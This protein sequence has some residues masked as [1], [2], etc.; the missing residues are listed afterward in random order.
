M[1]MSAAS[2]TSTVVQV[3]G[4][5]ITVVAGLPHLT[6]TLPAGTSATHSLDWLSAHT[7]ATPLVGRTQTLQELRELLASS[8]PVRVRVIT[9]STGRGK[10]RLAMELCAWAQ[11]QGWA[12]GFAQSEELARFLTQPDLGSWGWQRPTLVVVDSAA[13]HAQ[14]LSEWLRRLTQR[15]SDPTPPLR[16]LLLERHASLTHGW[17]ALMLNGVSQ[18]A[19]RK[20]ALLHPPEPVELPP[21]SSEEDCLAL[22][23]GLKARLTPEET[24]Q[25][26]QRALLRAL[27]SA[28][29]ELDPLH[30]MMA[31]L[32]YEQSGIVALRRA[33]LAAGLARGEAQRIDEAASAFGVDPGLAV[34]LAA[35]VTLTQ[36]MSV[37]MLTDLALQESTAL[38]VPCE[39]RE[40]AHCLQAVLPGPGGISPVLPD[41]IGEAFVL[42]QEL[43]NDTVL[44]CHA[45][46]PGAVTRTAIGCVED[47]RGQAIALGWLEAILLRCAE[48]EQGLLALA[49]AVPADSVP[50][51]GLRLSI[52]QH[53]VQMRSSSEAPLARRAGALQFLGQAHARCGERDAALIAARQASALY[54][55]IIRSTPG[56]ERLEVAPSLVRLALL[57]EE[58]GAAPEAL[59]TCRDAVGLYRELAQLHPGAFEGELAGSLHTLAQRLA[60]QGLTTKALE[61]VQEARG[62]YEQLARGG[63]ETAQP[64]LAGCLVTMARL[65]HAQQPQAIQASEEA[66][67]LYRDLSAHHP[68]MFTGRLAEA[69]AALA[70]FAASEGRHE[71]SVQAAQEATLLYRELSLKS[72][73]PYAVRLAEALMGLAHLL[74]S[75]L[76]H[77]PA[78]EAA[79]EATLL[80]RELMA[81][82]PGLRLA[83]AGSLRVL[84]SLMQELKRQE[85]AM[86]VLEEAVG[87]YRELTVPGTE[88]RVDLANSL[89]HLARMQSEKGRHEQTLATTLEA[90]AV[91]R[92]LAGLRPEMFQGALATALASLSRVQTELGLREAALATLQETVAL[93]RQLATKRPTV[94]MPA[95]A[96]SIMQLSALQQAVG[97][98]EAA[99]A[100]AEEA[101]ALYRR[102]VEQ[103]PAVYQAYL[104]QALD[105]Q[106]ALLESEGKWRPALALAE[107]SLGLRRAL[108]A[109]RPAAY[110]AGLADLLAHIATLRVHLGEHELAL[111]PAQ[112]AVQ[113]RRGQKPDDSGALASSLAE[114][115]A[116][117][118][119]LGQP[120]A[121]LEA[122]QEALP[123]YRGLAA[124]Q[125]E[126]RAGLA[127]VQG[128]VALLLADLG[129]QAEGLPLAQESLA[130]WRE[131]QREEPGKY[132]DE[133]A[134]AADVLAVC[135]EPPTPARAMLT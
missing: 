56:N 53:L 42:A 74:G 59:V 43:D 14:G 73:D 39:P 134:R 23:V 38:E 76:R 52:A 48:D 44:R 41:L 98:R 80:Y 83:L 50:L 78:L 45:L 70:S 132:S 90:S 95:L 57:L 118:S 106:T 60:A 10:T 58:L 22:L 114:L 24:A 133:V 5:G 127:A 2:Q 108:V 13:E 20:R 120:Q 84:G 1:Q 47:L 124:V 46:A 31:V 49:A 81:T 112:E 82:Q 79:F 110:R 99:I 4:D 135:R 61:A 15:P 27:R 37:E 122:A 130:T 77:E 65:L 104:A 67:N 109:Q 131:L 26:T 93:R 28:Q 128:T 35:C 125:R 36:G 100:S 6:L 123:L 121:A 33:G 29:Q 102:L 62:L 16:L 97:L 126:H 129:R 94:L 69:L 55:R 51:A 68:E 7:R 21:L 96:A 87:L 19:A 89:T 3:V 101:T 34:H 11:T 63:Q 25:G 40:L 54:G 32:T 64:A 71:E 85:T 116:L 66:V 92:E 117:Y 119:D 103:R 30:L 86:Q 115:A 88:G 9:G 105:A 75:Q 91:Y 17:C 12:A 72:P 107:E 18:D 113:L 8:R 111:A